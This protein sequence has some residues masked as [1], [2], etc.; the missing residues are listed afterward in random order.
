[1]RRFLRFASAGLVLIG[2][3][4]AATAQAAGNTKPYTANVRVE[5]A[6]TPNTFRL[7]LTNDPKA[8]QALGSANFT[9]PAHFSA[10]DGTSAISNRSEEHTSE[11]QSRI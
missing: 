1:M 11:L 5:N 10:P 3:I 4:A 8:Q 6:L 9:L 7:T 2:V